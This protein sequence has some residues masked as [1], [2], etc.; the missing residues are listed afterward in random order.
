MDAVIRTK[1][2][3]T[4]VRWEKAAKSKSFDALCNVP[5]VETKGTLFIQVLENGTV[6]TNVYLRRLHNFALDMNWILCPIIPRPQWPEFTFG[7]RRAITADEHRKIIERERN[8]ERRAFYELCWHLGGSQT[9]IATLT[10]ESIDWQT[11]TLSY[12]RK[13]SGTPAHIQFGTAAGDIASATAIDRAAVPMAGN[14]LLCKKT[15]FPNRA[16]RGRCLPPQYFVSVSVV[17]CA[18]GQVPLVRP[19]LFLP[20]ES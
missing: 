12:T 1:T 5:L 19:F 8:P 13:K 15:S 7:E 4:R 9:D 6:S 3:P 20:P 11:K 14:R 16:G 17:E 10:A 18:G 2:G